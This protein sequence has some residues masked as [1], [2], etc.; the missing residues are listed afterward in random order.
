MK[1]R[2]DQWSLER[3]EKEIYDGRGLA[4]PHRNAI[5]KSRMAARFITGHSVLDLACGGGQLANLI[6]D[7]RYLGVDTSPSQL[8]RARHYC[9][10]PNATFIEADITQLPDDI[11]RFDCVV[12]GE[13]LEH[14]DDPGVIARIA[15]GHARMR[16]IVT[17]PVNMGGGDH[18]WQDFSK[19][20]LETFFGGEAWLCEKFWCIN[21]WY[22]WVGVWEATGW[23][24]NLSVC[25]ICQDE[26]ELLPYTLHCIHQSLPI[27]R[28]T[29]VVIVDGGSQDGTLDVIEEWKDKLPIVLLE[30]PYDTAGKQKNRGLDLCTGDWVLGLDAD[31]TFTRNLG[32]VFAAGTFNQKPIWDFPMYYT[33]EDEFH[34][35][36]IKSP[37]ATTRLW[38]NEYRYTRDWHEQLPHPPD[39]VMCHDV[40]FFEGSLLQTRRALL[41]RGE[42]WQPYAKEVSKVGSS[43]GPISR[44]LAMEYAGRQRGEPFPPEIRK[45]IVP[46]EGLLALRELDERRHKEAKTPLPQEIMESRASLKWI[47]RYMEW[48][49]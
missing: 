38:R 8:R 26:V 48:E 37:G 21:E 22:H 20:D 46:R 39:R 12:L 36:R 19:E 4:A 16:V 10:N 23:E 30:H 1:K 42:R 7:K 5:D 15:L 28:L 17:V 35:L 13:T 31:M 18:V 24:P 14:F 27:P 41:A 44:Y 45:L 34:T 40:R 29:E 43:H 11:K 2:G 47:K 32:S 3:Q 9:K 25:I 6:D 33:V 49:D